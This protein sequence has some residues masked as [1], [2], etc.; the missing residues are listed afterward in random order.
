MVN[1]LFFGS[2]SIDELR[3][4]NYR[5][6]KEC[7]IHSFLFKNSYFSCILDIKLK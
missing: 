7:L 5:H 4:L 3:E 1:S 2:K 6:S